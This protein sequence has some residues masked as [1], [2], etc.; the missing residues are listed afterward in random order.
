MNK[1]KQLIIIGGGTSKKEGLSK[2]LWSKLNGKLTFG[3]N[4]SYKC[5]KS[6]VQMFVDEL[7]YNEQHK[8]L[9]T[10]S[11]IIGKFHKHIICYKCKGQKPMIK[12]CNHC[13]KLGYIPKFSNTIMLKDTINYNRNLKKGVYKSALVGLFALSIG[14]YLLNEGDE[15]YL[16]GYDF[17]NLNNNRDKKGRLFTHSYQGEL[18]HRGIGKVSYYNSAGKIKGKIRAD[19]DF[20]VFA[21]EKKIKIY[22]V[23]PN[24]KINIFEKIDYDTF[25]NKLDKETFNQEE[26]REWIKEKIRRINNV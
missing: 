22:N 6:T 17:G 7:F 26:L 19:E 12:S 21:D 23:S 24:S 4:Y 1:T 2:D 25:F 16:L 8:E 14:I 15:I 13:N 9:K 10:L 18:E 3:L 20:G 11:L 5:F